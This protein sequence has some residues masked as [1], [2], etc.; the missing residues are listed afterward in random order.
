MR[1]TLHFP[2]MLSKGEHQALKRLARMETLSAA[3]VVRRLIIREARERG[4][5][6]SRVS[7]ASD[8]PER[9]VV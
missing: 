4:I 5:L 9:A 6:P 1:R 3:A 8:M 2:I 7:A